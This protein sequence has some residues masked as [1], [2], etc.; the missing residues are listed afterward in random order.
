MKTICK[1]WNEWNVEKEIGRGSY[2]TVYKCFKEVNGAREYS[3]IKVI[4]VPQNEY[5]L[6]EVSLEK[7]TH[8]QSK[9]YYKDI[10]DDLVKEIE[11]LKAL[12]GTKNIVEIYDAEI[13][14][15][16]D[17]IGW[18]ILI[19][20]ELLTDFN[21][22][23]SDKKF[24]E[25]EVVK[26]GLDLSSA[27]S[28]CHKA[29]IVHRDIKPEN[30]FVDDNG[31]FKLGDFGVAK[32]ME[33]TQGSMS[34]KG[35]YNYMSPEVFGGRKSDGRADMYSLALV[36]YKLL[37]NDRLP[38]LD[39]NK[40]IVR[41]SERQAA[42]EK[43]IKGEQ[44]PEI[45][46]VSKELNAVILKACA[47]KNTDRQKNIDEF[48]AQLE[49]LSAG[50]KLINKGII[51]FIV[52]AVIVAVCGSSVAAVTYKSS[53][54]FRNFVNGTESVVDVQEE[55]Q[56]PEPERVVNNPKIATMNTAW[57]AVD[58]DNNVDGKYLVEGTDYSDDKYSIPYMIDL[59]T[60]TY[61]DLR[62]ELG[63]DHKKSSV[64][65]Y[66]GKSYYYVEEK[67]GPDVIGPGYKIYRY[68]IATQNSMEIFSNENKV[69]VELVY[70]DD[71]Y[72]YIVEKDE[73][74]DGNY[75]SVSAN[76][77][78]YDLSEGESIP[79]AYDVYATV[80]YNGY[81]IC[82]TNGDGHLKVASL[83]IYDTVS[84]DFEPI[85]NSVVDIGAYYIKDDRLY[86][87]ESKNNHNDINMCRYDMETKKT[88]VVS[89]LSASGFNLDPT[90]V[91]PR[92]FNE[93][94]ILLSD[95]YNDI[96]DLYI[97]SYA[98]EKMNKVQVPEAAVDSETYVL[99]DAFV[100]KSV[101]DHILLVFEESYK[102]ELY[103]VLPSGEIKQLGKERYLDESDK[104]VFI[105]D[106]KAIVFT[107][108]E[109]KIKVCDFFGSESME[110][111]EYTERQEMVR[112]TTGARIRIGPDK[113]CKEIYTLKKGESVERIA[114]GDNGWSK[115]IYEDQIVYI[116]SELLEVVEATDDEL[117]QLAKT[118]S[119]MV[120]CYEVDEFDADSE[121]GFDD[122]MTYIL[123]DIFGV[124][125][126]YDDYFKW[127]THV[128][129]V[130]QEY[131]SNNDKYVAKDPLKKLDSTYAYVK[132]PADKVEWLLENVY[133]Q[134][135][136][137]NYESSWYYYYD[138]YYYASTGD[139]RDAGYYSV[140][141]NYEKIDEETY[142]FNVR[143]N[144]D[145][146]DRLYARYKIVAK[147]DSLNDV[148]YWSIKQ[149]KYNSSKES[150]V[151]REFLYKEFSNED[152]EEYAMFDINNDGSFEMIVLSHEEEKNTTCKVYTVENSNVVLVGSFVLGGELLYESN[153]NTLCYSEDYDN[154]LLCDEEMTEIKS[155]EISLNDKKIETTERTFNAETFY[156]D[157]VD[158]AYINDISLLRY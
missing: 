137:R 102:N 123:D 116:F 49:K 48:K 100:D 24:T 9:A 147:K 118:V 28:V 101:S 92:A 104:N 128:N 143:T 138:G 40:Q 11:I 113:N 45:S 139:D 112:A 2:G 73:T 27:L 129:R 7:M 114:I 34:V 83:W 110:K 67:Y 90:N 119:A 77:R 108:E 53:E 70:A 33:K 155:T 65:M 98:E 4:S 64:C 135:V 29:K 38:F 10:A 133:N 96:F 84:G 71:E 151:Y 124:Y 153:S 32:Q 158:R 146:S 93:N 86:F 62:K 130:S 52:A 44:L 81:I 17:G 12:K 36:M 50:K 121:D 99:K 149:L 122:A 16:E 22:Y 136:N 14:E 82:A 41:Y 120:Y 75:H 6:S 54:T 51:K 115:V 30:I 87:Y 127:N 157:R 140:V 94:N 60:G 85:S 46:G 21:T 89:N 148:K 43:R 31:N 20:M 145:G 23:S 117:D 107:E 105:M 68:D 125:D 57:Y 18:Y 58:E 19:R 13:V 63:L 25:A 88:K 1:V 132:F 91:L 141:E 8:E 37:N 47:F 78:G 106:S 15:K 59:K 144:Y 35:T 66:D 79:V 154:V 111:A 72:L 131:D 76:L 109:N 56:Q 69:F 126:F 142:S 156:K 26:L 55:I 42:F 150:A 95:S 97:W 103:E 134:K 61:T 152:D 74:D 5:E 39:P 3:A 80:Y